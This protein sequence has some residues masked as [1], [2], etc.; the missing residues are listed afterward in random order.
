[1]NNQPNYS[2][3]GN[4]VDVEKVSSFNR[5]SGWKNAEIT[6]N[7]ANFDYPFF[8]THEYWEAF[9]L[10]EGEISHYIGKKHFRMKK[11]D[12][13]LVRP[14]D[15]HMLKA[16]NHAQVKMINFA[17]KIEYAER[18]FELFSFQPEN[19]TDNAGLSF[20]V[21]EQ[22]LRKLISETIV[23][24]SQKNSPLSKKIL[25]CKVLFN[26]FFN[27]YLSQKVISSKN[28]PDWLESLL[29]SISDP[30]ISEHKIKT[31]LVSKTNYS[32]SS[33][34]PLVTSFFLCRSIGLYINSTR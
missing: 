26:E 11:G 14:T 29:V 21:S 16:V 6:F 22:L 20:T 25:W 18:L 15:N 28:T 5:I 34:F 24:Q 2:V 19:H 23:I 8:H 30:T 13:W 3:L 7:W 4:V 10:V 1:M 9:V 32:Y 31:E 27:E 12:A 33:L 17:L